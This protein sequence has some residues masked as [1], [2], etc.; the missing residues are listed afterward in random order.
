MT[1]FEIAV[2]LIAL[3]VAASGAVLLR[4]EARRID[5]RRDRRRHHRD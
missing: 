1:L 2:P 4:M 5:I 3:A